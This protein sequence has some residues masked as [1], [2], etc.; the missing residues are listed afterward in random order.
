MKLVI[1][2]AAFVIATTAA[3]FAQGPHL[4]DA[5]PP[6]RC[7]RVAFRPAPSCAVT[8]RWRPA[9]R[10]RNVSGPMEFG[11]T[12]PRRATIRPER[13]PSAVAAAIDR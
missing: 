4:G 11:N 2:S 7:A 10:S 12:R 5:N 6:A 13:A 9:F 8:T 3:S 1:L